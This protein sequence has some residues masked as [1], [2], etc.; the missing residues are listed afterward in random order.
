[1]KTFAKA[2]SMR[3]SSFSLIITK[4][5]HMSEKLKKQENAKNQ[6]NTKNTKTRTHT[7]NNQGCEMTSM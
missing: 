7:S 3:A 4:I 2:F 6:K 1:M 5:A